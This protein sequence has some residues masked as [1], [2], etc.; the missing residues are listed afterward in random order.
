M[1]LVTIRST[2]L[3]SLFAS[4]GAALAAPEF[5]DP[6]EIASVN[7]VLNGL[8][9]VAPAGVNVAGKEVVTTVYNGLLMPPLLRVQPGDRVRL[10]PATTPHNR[11]T[12]TT[13]VS[14]SPP[15]VAA[16]TCSCHHS[17]YHVLI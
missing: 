3:A 8:L 6:P 15:A 2:V 11:R 9:T 13:M 17:G 14:R 5:A 16:T 7:G 4:G 1:R 12:F 10:Q